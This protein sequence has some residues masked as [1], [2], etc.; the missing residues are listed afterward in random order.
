MIRSVKDHLPLA[1]FI[2]GF[3]KLLPISLGL[4]DF[5]GGHGSDGAV[6]LSK[7]TPQR[8]G[9]RS[10]LWRWIWISPDD[11]HSILRGF[12]RRTLRRFPGGWTI[13]TL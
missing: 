7:E 3:L 13:W 8:L 10:L 4:G 9:A 11:Q 6:S 2:D 5:V 12:A 1:P